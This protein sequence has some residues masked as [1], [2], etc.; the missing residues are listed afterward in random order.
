MPSPLKGWPRPYRAGLGLTEA[1]FG[2]TEAGSGLSE[3]CLTLESIKM[4]RDFDTELK[5]L[6]SFI[7]GI[8]CKKSKVH[9]IF[10]LAKKEFSRSDLN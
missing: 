8:F 2:L 4:S 3:A 9:S 10:D 7:H 5:G 1:D 6:F